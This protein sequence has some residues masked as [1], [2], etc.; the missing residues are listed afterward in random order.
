[1]KKWKKLSEEILHKNPWCEYKH[2]RYRLPSGK[3]G[4]YYYMQTPGAVCL[5]PVLD[6]GRVVMVKQWR[7]LFD[8]ES[9]EFP[10]GGVKENQ[11]FDEAA[12]AE[13]AEETGYS[14]NF[15][16]VGSFV[17]TNGQVVETMKVFIINN[18]K[19]AESRPDET[20]DLEIIIKNPEE[21]DKMIEENEIWCGETIAA[22]T[23]ARKYLIK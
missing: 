10:A 22:W 19:E 18:L 1:M 3:E 8:R 2:D 7:Y 6:D 12:R 13:L 11:S 4:D 23:L 5:V 14:G 20:E 17:P 15:H 9:V 16:L 21:I